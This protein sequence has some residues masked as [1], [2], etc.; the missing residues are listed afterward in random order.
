MTNNQCSSAS[1]LEEMHRSP[2]RTVRARSLSSSRDPGPTPRMIA[3]GAMAFLLESENEEWATQLEKIH[4]GMCSPQ[5]D[6]HKRPRVNSA[7]ARP[8]GCRQQQSIGCAT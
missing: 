4:R 3:L 2:N 8:S 6:L 1:S 5:A 7:Q